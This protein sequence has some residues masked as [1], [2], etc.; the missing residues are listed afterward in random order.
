MLLNKSFN[1]AGYFSLLKETTCKYY[2]T[3]TL[4]SCHLSCREKLYLLR[5]GGTTWHIPVHGPRGLEII[6]CVCVRV[7]SYSM[8]VWVVSTGIGMP[9]M[10]A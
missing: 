2:R 3:L 8:R 1:A 4:Q 6:Q 9:G 10:F 7:C 5:L